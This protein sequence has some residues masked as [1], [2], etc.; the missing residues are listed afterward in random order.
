[1]AVTPR[2]VGGPIDPR[3]HPAWSAWIGPGAGPGGG[4]A[5]PAR[6][7]GQPSSPRSW[8]RWPT[9]A[10]GTRPGSAPLQV[11]PD[12]QV[13]PVPADLVGPDLPGAVH[14]ALLAPAD[15]R[16][17]GAHYTPPALAARLVAWAVD[18]WAGAG[19]GPWRV[20]DLSVG[21][22]AFLLA[23]ARHRRA[24]GLPPGDVLAG[25]AGVDVDGGA[26]AAAEAALVAWARG[27]G[28]D[29]AGP[30]PSLVVGDGTDPSPFGEGGP[31]PGQVDLVVGNPPFRG[32]LGTATARDRAAAARLRERWGAAAGGYVDDAALFLHVACAWPRPGGRVVLVQPESVLGARDA[33]GVRGAVG[34]VADL[35]GLWVAGEPT[36]AAAVDVCAPVLQIRPAGERPAEVPVARAE[37]VVVRPSG[38][39][40]RPDGASWAPL[41]ARSRGV[42]AVVLDP[43]TGTL[44]DL[45]TATAGFRQHF[46]ALAPH[47]SELPDGVDPASGAPRRG[48]GAHHRPGRPGGPPLGVAAGPDRRVVVAAARRWT[49]APSPPTTR[50]WPPGCATGCGPRWWSRP[51]PGWWR[52]RWTRPGGSCPASPSC[53]SSPSTTETAADPEQVLWLVVAA[54]SAPPVTAWAM[55]RAAGTARHR[56]ALR[57]APRQLRAVPLPVDRAGWEAAASE[58]RAGRPLAEVGPLLTAAYGLDA[59]HPVTP[60]WRDRLPRPR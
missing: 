42:P 15:R 27:E 31:R 55:A 48:P 37:G 24:D 20:L 58:L 25:L 56:D 29:G 10:G 35:V 6:R 2:P 38:A 3:R 41:L 33:E 23:A 5:G 45:A 7:A 4:V 59:D 16:A 1:M 34:E 18:G 53:R 19:S 9:G 40:P 44:G 36:F 14:E 52:P 47:L 28:W 51:R 30:G 49:C 60:W 26:V 39:D 13:A 46:Y 50:P 32:Q 43:T 54:L 21:G 8:P 57:L 11:A 22:G 12:P 17:A